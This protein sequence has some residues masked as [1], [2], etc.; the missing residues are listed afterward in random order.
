MRNPVLT[1]EEFRRIG[2]QL[3]DRIADYR[4]TVADRP[5]MSG[6]APGALRAALPKQAPGQPESFDAIFSDLDELI[7]PG[8]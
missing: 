8:L 1:P 7:I 5:V 3:I 6:N 4:A 2:H